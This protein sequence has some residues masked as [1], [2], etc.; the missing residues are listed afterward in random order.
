MNSPRLF[1]RTPLPGVCEAL[2]AGG[3]MGE[4]GGRWTTDLD[5]ARASLCFWSCESLSSSAIEIA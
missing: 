1:S 2:L 5:F 3:G 4:G